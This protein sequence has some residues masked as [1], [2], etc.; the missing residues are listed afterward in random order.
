[1]P[2]KI[3]AENSDIIRCENLSYSYA[4]KFHNTPV[5]NNF[6]LN[7]KKGEHIAIVGRSGVGKSTLLHLIGTLDTQDTGDIIIKGRHIK[8][9]SESA[10]TLFRRKYFGFMYQQTHLLKSFSA[11]D[12][13]AMPLRILGESKKIARKKSLCPTGKNKPH[14]ACRTST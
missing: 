7:V 8:K 5:L 2:Q 10:R 12:N 3:N 14:R 4:S 9:M 13:I 6:N 1:M 11:L